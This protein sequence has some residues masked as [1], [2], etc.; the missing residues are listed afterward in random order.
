VRDAI[1]AADQ[2]ITG[3]K[4]LYDLGSVCCEGF[5]GEASAGHGNVG[6][7]QVEDFTI[8]VAGSST[9]WSQ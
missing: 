9:F 4:L 3:G 1:I 7:D 5:R 6:D 2:A 8:P